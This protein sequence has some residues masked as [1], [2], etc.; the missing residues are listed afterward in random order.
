MRYTPSYDVIL[1]HGTVIDGSGAARFIADVGVRG[2]R[3]AAIGALASAAGIEEYDVAGLIVA[4]GFIDAH[5]HDDCVCITAP[6]MLAK[7]S[8]GVTTVVVGNCGLSAA[9]IRFPAGVPEPF[10]LLGER[11]DF[12]FAHF[13]DYAAAVDAAQPRVN[14]AALVGHSTLRAACMRD[15]GRRASARE[16]A[17]M[18]AHLAEAMAAGAQGLSSG[19]FYKPAAAADSDELVALAAIVAQAGGVYTTHLRD[20]YDGVIDALN[21]AFATAARA[22]LPLIVSHHKCAGVRNWGRSTET[23]A[24]IDQT[25]QQ[26]A[27]SLDCY[28]Y[29]A[30]SSV[31]EPEL[32]DGEIDILINS[33]QPHP[34]C[35]GRRLADI[36]AD[37]NASQRE[38]AQRL[39]PGSACY[40]QIREDDMR[41]ILSHPLCMVGSD[42]LPN[43]PLPHPRLWGTFPRVLGHYAREQRLFPLEE[44]VRKMT[45]LPAERFGL[46]GRGR[47]AAGCAADITIFNAD[48]IADRAT[49]PQ[50]QQIAAG[51]EH[52]FVNGTAAWS[53]G[54]P[55]HRRAGRF[56][57]RA[58]H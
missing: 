50:P 42:G 17:A 56:L 40:F 5:T 11:E 23:L 8:Q 47:I 51:I 35:A 1:R 7:I 38:A 29:T 37:W 10:N 39:V 57:R 13:A 36:A 3:I 48:T 53:D 9:P 20:E 14:V 27:V 43:D 58:N 26:Q 19:V 22:A 31:L 34:E 33:S 6:N 18:Q 52:V 28:P 2:E 16:L 12:R 49:Y 55:S 24:L 30:G 15:L 46:S 21:E 54:I 44:A 32:A 25:A 41:R 45:G 4:P